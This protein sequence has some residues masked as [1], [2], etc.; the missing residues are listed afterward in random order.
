MDE[1]YSSQPELTNQP[2][3]H[4]DVEYFMDS[5]SFVQEDTCFARYTVVTM[6]TI[7]EA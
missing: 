5:S 4:L 2:I 3:I 1:V 7:I 6:G